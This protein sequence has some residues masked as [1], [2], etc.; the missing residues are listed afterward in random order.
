MET[1]AGASGIKNLYLWEATQGNRCYQQGEDRQMNIWKNGARGTRQ[2]ALS[3]LSRSS[4]VRQNLK[5]P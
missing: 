4:S 3:K 5:N 2:T 1:V